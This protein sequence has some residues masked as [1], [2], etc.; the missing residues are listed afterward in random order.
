MKEIVLFHSYNYTKCKY[1]IIDNKFYDYNDIFLFELL[2]IPKNNLL[3]LLKVEKKMITKK[4]SFYNLTNSFYTTN[5]LKI[6]V[7]VNYNLLEKYTIE[8]NSIPD[9]DIFF[10]LLKLNFIKKIDLNSNFIS[11]ICLNN[12]NIKDISLTTTNFII[13]FNIIKFYNLFIDLN[14]NKINT[15]FEYSSINING[16]VLLYDITYF[17]IDELINYVIKN[18]KKINKVLIITK[19][20]A[21]LWNNKLQYYKINNIKVVNYDINNNENSNDIN[22]SNTYDLLIVD[23]YFYK[24]DIKYKNIIICS[25]NLNNISIN[26]LLNILDTYYNINFS[27]YILTYDILY[28]IIK[29]ILFIRNYKKK[30]NYNIKLKTINTLSLYNF[31]NINDIDKAHFN[32]KCHCNICYK[33]IKNNICKTKCNHYYCQSCIDTLFKNKN[34]NKNEITCPLCRIK[35]NNKSIFKLNVNNNFK[36]LINNDVLELIKNIKN[37]KHNIFIISYSNIIAYIKLTIKNINAITNINTIKNTQN[38]IYH[39]IKKKN[40]KK[41]LNNININKYSFFIINCSNFNI[42]HFLNNQFEYVFN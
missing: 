38:I 7:K 9:S 19:N 21:K 25:D 26:S 5:N 28:K 31:S 14:K 29:N 34:K 30:F 13:D 35:L 11:T 12:K 1:K 8:N 10:K 33:V 20:N 40:N 36:E 2:N 41:Y 22:N 27:N 18:K 3:F 32:N 39:D 16:G 37:S 15:N 23:N 24:V 6:F 42:D 17:M 4:Y